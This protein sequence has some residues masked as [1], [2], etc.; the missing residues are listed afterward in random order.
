[1]IGLLAPWFLAGGV[2]VAVPIVLHLLKRNPET[3]VKFSAVH[4]LREAPVERADRRRLR[5]LLLLALRVAALLLLALAFARP[6]VPA[7]VGAAASGVTVLA[8]DT[9]LSLSAPGQFERARQLARDVID[10]APSNERVAV[11]TFADA[12]I[13]AA[14]PSADRALARAAID[15]AAPGFGATRYRAA[16]ARAADVLASAR[17]GAGR[18]VVVTDLQ[19]S[20][21]NAGDRASLPASVRLDVA[22]VGPPPANLAVASVRRSGDR[23]VASVL[24]TGADAR[25]VRVSVAGDVAGTP[26][27]TATVP[28]AAGG[29]AE[30]TLPVPAGHVARVTATDPAG[31]AGDNERYLVLDASSRPS[32]IVLTATG[33]LPHEAFYLEQAL[34]AGDARTAARVE[35]VGGGELGR[36]DP[37]RLGQATAVVWLSSRN[38]DRRGRDRLADYLRMGGRLVV[39]AGPELDREV[40][41]EVLGGEH[42]VTWSAP[43][44]VSGGSGATLVPA[45]ARHPIF[46]AFGPGA[47]S[48]GLVRF[49]RMVVVEAAGCPVV[50]RFTDS[51]AALVECAVGDGRLLVLASDLDN[52]WNDFP[53]HASFVPFVQEMLRYL[54]G[55]APR[56]V[57]ML[58]GELAGEAGRTPGVTTLAGP[59]GTSRLAVVNV[60][61]RESDPRRLSVPEFEAAV[62]RLDEPAVSGAGVEGQRQEDRQHIWQYL[63]AVMVVALGVESVV[64]RRA[65]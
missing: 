24:N 12:A 52:R 56:A 31:L 6:F 10:R 44:A 19:Q 46:Q 32:V 43:Q 14:A 60:D 41:A 17:S 42:A 9:S 62:A 1:M 7:S 28:V 33:D 55:G 34:A 63:L 25:E 38:L 36:W 5:E 51:H 39:A 11:V 13:E 26:T 54:A 45:D 30:V 22:D 18:V 50:A 16:I 23:I 3:R 4:L 59:A 53:L 21:W 20:G 48:L 40:V 2:A 15:A 65:V 37:A 47:P 61:P 64:S 49:D 35:G 8:L 58:V 29:S 57:D 27:Q